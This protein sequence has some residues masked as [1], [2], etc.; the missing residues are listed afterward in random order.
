MMLLSTDD[1]LKVFTYIAHDVHDWDDFLQ[2]VNPLFYMDDNCFVT[3]FD[4]LYA[5]GF[6][7]RE[8]PGKSL[9]PISLAEVTLIANALIDNHQ[10][11]W[12]KVR[13]NTGVDTYATQV[14]R[15]LGVPI[16]KDEMPD[17]EK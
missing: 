3:T 4:I 6:S 17:M 11:L 14:L 2:D 13:D 5:L 12:D 16:P 9:L 15:S 1:A 10:I 8:I 7:E